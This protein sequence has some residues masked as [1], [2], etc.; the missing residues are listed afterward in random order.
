MMVFLLV[1]LLG[2]VLHGL[3]F[4]SLFLPTGTPWWLAPLMILI[5]LFAYLARPVS[6]S[7]RLAANMVAGHVLIKV[8]AGFIVSMAFYL[9]IVPIPFVSILIG[10]EIFVAILQAYIFTILSCVYLNDAINLH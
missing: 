7:L 1:T 5:E 10:F 4:L 9:K 3:H 6:L 2:F 8:I